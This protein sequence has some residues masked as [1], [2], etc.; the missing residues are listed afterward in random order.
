MHRTSIVVFGLLLAACSQPN[1]RTAEE[2]A[3]LAKVGEMTELFNQHAAPA[4]Y[5]DQYN[6]EDMVWTGFL[7]FPPYRASAPREQLKAIVQRNHDLAPDRK[8]TVKSIWA[9]GD[10]VIKE[11]EI[12][13]ARRDVH[14]IAVSRFRDGKIVETRTYSVVVP[15]EGEPLHRTPQERAAVATMEAFVEAY[16]AQEEGWFERFHDAGIAYVGVIPV[17]GRI[18]ADFASL[19]AMTDGIMRNVPDRHFVVDSL[20]VDGESAV[21]EGSWTGTAGPDHPTLNAGQRVTHHY[22]GIYQIRDGKFIQLRE[23]LVP[24]KQVAAAASVER[25]P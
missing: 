13:S 10:T 3:N 20:F 21:L 1:A 2:Q 19:K 15:R 18:T 25:T 24:L 16:N 8:M 5:F 14:E 4:D 11:H 9:D 6:S 22:A 12:N 7:S 23:Y 17:P